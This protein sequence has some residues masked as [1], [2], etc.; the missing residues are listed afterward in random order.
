[1]Y[2]IKRGPKSI[3]HKAPYHPVIICNKLKI[4]KWEAGGTDKKATVW[5]HD[6]TCF[7]SGWLLD[8]WQGLD[9]DYFGLV[10]DVGKMPDGSPSAFYH[11]RKKE[12]FTLI[13]GAIWWDDK[14]MPDWLKNAGVIY[15]PDQFTR[16]C[17]L[18]DIADDG[19][20]GNAWERPQPDFWPQLKNKK[21]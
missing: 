17:I 4:A 18:E 14:K 12:P 6:N 19:V 16:Q 7:E 10:K 15:P 21:V 8:R 20:R 9:L 2:L 13:K 3:N 11:N 5:S 1:M